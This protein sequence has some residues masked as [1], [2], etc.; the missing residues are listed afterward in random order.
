M[1]ALEA[2]PPLRTPLEVVDQLV[3]FLEVCKWFRTCLNQLGVTMAEPR[4]TAGI[5]P[6]MTLVPNICRQHTFLRMAPS[7]TPRS[8][9]QQCP[10]TMVVLR[11]VVRT[12]QRLTCNSLTMAHTPALMSTVAL[13]RSQC[14]VAQVAQAC[15]ERH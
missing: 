12:A 15:Q 11:L 5:I 2:L 4:I 13:K 8:R 1:S 3:L 9:I 14:Q 10:C 6:A 7:P